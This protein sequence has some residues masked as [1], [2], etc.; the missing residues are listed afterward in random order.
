MVIE[1]FWTV[2]AGKIGTAHTGR[3]GVVRDFRPAEI[4]FCSMNGTVLLKPR[5][6]VTPRETLK[7]SRRELSR[8]PLEGGE[9]DRITFEVFAT[10]MEVE[11]SEVRTEEVLTALGKERAEQRSA[12][13]K[14]SWADAQLLRKA[15]EPEDRQALENWITARLADPL[16]GGQMQVNH[17]LR[18]PSR[19]RWAVGALVSRW[20]RWAPL[21][22]QFNHRNDV[23]KAL[24]VRSGSTEY[25]AGG[26][27]VASRVAEVL[28]ERRAVRKAE[29]LARNNK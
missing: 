15:Q 25:Y 5:D 20:L 4:E 21:E 7:L 12:L 23:L 26:Q 11:I 17:L 18:K 24:Q 1:K 13:E 14:Q 28:E 9:R 8:E 2:V 6:G 19:A 3:D 29:W 16:M 22:G 27:L 10:F